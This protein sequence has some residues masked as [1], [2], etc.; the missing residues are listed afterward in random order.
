VNDEP[1]LSEQ[2]ADVARELAEAGDVHETLQR[3]VELAVQTIESCEHAG[4]S[5]VVGDHVETPA[6]SDPVPAAIDRIQ[7]GAGEGPYRDAIR[8]HEVFATG[9][10]AREERWSRFSA[11]VVEHTGV[12]SMLAMRLFADQETMGSLNLYATTVDAFDD[13]AHSVAS[14]FAA[15][16]AVA[17]RAAQQQQRLEEAT[18]SHDVDVIGK[19]KG[20]LMAHQEIDEDAAVEQMRE[21]AH[22]LDRDLREVADDIVA[23]RQRP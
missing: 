11:E 9:D 14:I 3:L 22:A 15:H 6:Q 12:R 21:M 4:V 19:A 17:L 13:D 5:L 16:A 8:D 23:R 20:L 2:L 7:V 10:L 1:T 18:E